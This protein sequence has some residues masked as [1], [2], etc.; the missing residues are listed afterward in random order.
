MQLCGTMNAPLN[1]SQ[2]P[3][4]VLT[5]LAAAVRFSRHFVRPPLQ[6]LLIVVEPVVRW[7]LSLALVLGVLAALVFEVSAVGA[8]FSL[9]Q[10]I[11]GSLG[12]GVVLVL[13][14]GLLASVSR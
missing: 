12:F 2:E 1:R 11:A 13:Y 8:Q 14:C 4:S 6:A 3:N 10:L 5:V 7:I 9:L